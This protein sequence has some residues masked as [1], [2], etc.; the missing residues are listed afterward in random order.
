[1]GVVEG[2]VA[3]GIRERGTREFVSVPRGSQKIETVLLTWRMS[4]RFLFLLLP[5]VHNSQLD[6][7]VFYPAAIRNCLRNM[8]RLHTVRKAQTYR[9]GLLRS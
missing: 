5:L 9:A 6:I 1:M 7:S 2:N 3:G 8:M 4:K